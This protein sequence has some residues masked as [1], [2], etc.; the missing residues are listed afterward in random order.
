[1][2]ARLLVG[3]EE[4]IEDIDDEH[5][6]TVIALDALEPPFEELARALGTSARDDETYPGALV[7][8]VIDEAGPT[9]SE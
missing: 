8:R 7:A 5:I 2:R 9:S 4:F 3:D 6:E 1:M